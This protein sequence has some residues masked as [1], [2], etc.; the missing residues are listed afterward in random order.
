[1]TIATGLKALAADVAAIRTLASSAQAGA[2]AA[3]LS[4]S[5]AA[6]LLANEAMAGAK[7]IATSVF[8]QETP[9]ETWVVVHNMN[10]FP[11]VV[12]VGNSGTV[13]E[14]DISYDSANQITL[15]FSAALTGTAYL[16]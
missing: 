14:G 4:N 10:C 5:V 16:N 8:T 6:Q 9:S 15:T 13:T 3:A 7:G 12:V 11:I 1:M 2:S